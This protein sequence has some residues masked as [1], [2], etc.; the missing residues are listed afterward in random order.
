MA[1][2][3]HRPISDQ[4]W[5]GTTA[6]ACHGNKLYAV[7]SEQ[8]FELDPAS[9]KCRRL[10]EDRW[11]SLFMVSDGKSLYTIEGDGG[12]YRVKPTD[13]SSQPLGDGEWASTC[14]AAVVDGKLLLAN[15]GGEQL[16]AI[17]LATGKWEK[18]PTPAKAG[19]GVSFMAGEAGVLYTW[20]EGVIAAVY[21]RGATGQVIHEGEL[22]DVR[23]FVA[24][25]GRLYVQSGEDGN[26]YEIPIPA[27][28]AKSKPSIVTFAP[29]TERWAT[30]L[31]AS[32][33]DK[34]YT[35]E[36]EGELFEITPS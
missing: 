6:M 17:D 32:S 22:H 4:T 27:K 33:R 9:K 29:T 35:V 23:A 16:D 5:E 24:C 36:A 8:L 10:G 12:L 25:K 28:G 14:A 1:K 7:Q 2:A 20:S 15:Q 19:L 11:S 21:G 3:T 18:P 13:G 34:I 30:V 26:F 31:A